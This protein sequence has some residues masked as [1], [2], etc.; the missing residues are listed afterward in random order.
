M[1]SCAAVGYFGVRSVAAIQILGWA[2]N[3]VGFTGWDA[4]VR[5]ELKTRLRRGLKQSPSKIRSAFRQ[6]ESRKAVLLADVKD[7]AVYGLTQIL[8]TAG[9]EVQVLVD[10]ADKRQLFRRCPK[11]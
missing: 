1:A 10:E 8:Q 5:S 7:E 2:E 11:R 4:H 3:F 9:A 6:L